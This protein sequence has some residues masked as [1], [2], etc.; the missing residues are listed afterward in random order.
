MKRSVKEYSIKKKKSEA[1][2]LAVFF[3]FHSISATRPLGVVKRV[4]QV[5][6]I[7]LEEGGLRGLCE[8]SSTFVTM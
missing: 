8:P 3:C 2:V 1:K 7:L 6:V 5:T 4:A